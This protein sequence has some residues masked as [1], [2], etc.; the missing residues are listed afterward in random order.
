MAVRIKDKDLKPEFRSFEIREFDEERRTVELSFSSEEPYERWWGVEILDHSITSMKTSRLERSAPLLLDHDMTKQIGVIEQVRIEE[1]KGRATVR[2]SRSALA[3]EVFND[4]VDGIRRN[5]SVGYQINAVVLE[6]KEGDTETYRVTDW[7]PFEISIVSVPA[8]TSVGVGRALDVGEE[9]PTKIEEE[10]TMVEENKE[11]TDPIV[12]EEA[13][14]AEPVKVDD[15]LSGERSRTAEIMA[16]GE[17]FGMMDAAV[18]A[19]KNGETAENF[20]VKV[21]ENMENKKPVDTRASEIGMTQEEVKQYSFI[22]AINALANPSDKRAQEAAA[23]EFE[24]SRAAAEKMGRTARGLMIP[25][26][27]LKRDLEVMTTNGST[28]GKLVETSLLS[29]SF[30]DMLRN[31]ALMMQLGTVMT[32][33]TGNIAIPRQSGAATAYWLDESGAA[34]ESAQTLDQL[35]MSPKT[36]AAYTDIS[37]RMLLQSSIDVEMF[38]R[39]DLASV[40]ALAIDSA[41]IAGTGAS[42]QPTGI[43]NTS[44]IGLVALGTDGAAPTWAS[45]IALETAVATSNA[46]IGNL[47]YITNAKGRGKLKGTEIATGTAQFLWGRDGMINGYE[48][49]ATNQIPANLTKGS[50]TNLSAELFGNFSDL[51]IGLWGSLDINVDPYSLGTSGAV[52]VTAFQDCDIGIRHAA[53]F[54][55]IKDMVTA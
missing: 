47:K 12:T 18:N 40:L 22:K 24:A 20:R 6:S 36:V 43:L 10:K 35:A 37:R 44:G 30:I 19:V 26:D 14:A 27:V 28:G 53:S 31:R 52:R 32:G 3:T 39:S 34:T 5:V 17:R 50:G 33:L 25:I 38:V 11:V 51:I 8:D 2:F 21:I 1:R 42:G 48:A 7:E 49:L 4:V 15:V 29:G 16:Y 45:Q 54:A 41:A 46:D 23:F 13:K 9:L 55:A